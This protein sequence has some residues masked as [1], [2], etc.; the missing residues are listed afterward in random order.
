MVYPVKQ[1]NKV[2]KRQQF[3]FK[4]GEN[5][6]DSLQKGEETT[7]VFRSKQNFV[8]KN[9]GVLRLFLYH[10]NKGY[11][12]CSKKSLEKYRLNLPYAGGASDIFDSLKRYR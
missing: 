6:N 5:E 10:N 11:V 8:M 12:Q 2:Q 4:W 3:Y 9:L 1:A 7:S